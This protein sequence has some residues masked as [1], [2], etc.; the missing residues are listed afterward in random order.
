MIHNSVTAKYNSSY[1]ILIQFHSTFLGYLVKEM[2]S[3][4]KNI[5]HTLIKIHFN[6]LNRY[7]L[8]SKL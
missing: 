2:H 8:W 7:K 4:R 3:F 1:E 6:D 5:L